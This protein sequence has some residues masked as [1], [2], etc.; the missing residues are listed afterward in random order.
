MRDDI[1][2]FLQSEIDLGRLPGAAIHV[3]YDSEMMM[4]EAIGNR[5]AQQGTSPMNIETMFDVASLTKVVAALPAALKL[6]DEK[7]LD[8]D[9]KVSYFIPG[10]LQPDKKAITIKNLLTHTSGLPEHRPFYLENLKEQKVIDLICSEPLVAPIGKLVLYSDLNFIVLY[11]VIEAITETEFALYSKKEI[12]EPLEM[13]RTSFNPERSYRN[14]AAT[15]YDEKIGECKQGIVHDENAEAMGGVSGHAGLFS[16]IGD[17]GNYS[18]MI[19]NNGAFNNIQFL[20]ESSISLSST[21]NYSPSDSEPRG[22]GWMLNNPGHSSCGGY[23]SANSFGHTGFTGT[24]MWFDPFK[25]LH[26]ILLT[27]HVNLT[28]DSQ[29]IFSIRSK[30]HDIIAENTSRLH[31]RKRK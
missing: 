17:L 3:S 25:K 7:Q 11:K 18:S 1:I 13:F 26:V 21:I 24:S 2:R 20:K 31:T 15:E 12:F 4:Q 16:T 22:L 23:F 30:V 28:R 19:E 5:S 29:A 6:M 27:N 14:F 10:F 9:Q 8:L